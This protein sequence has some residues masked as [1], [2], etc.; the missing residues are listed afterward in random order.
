MTR[1]HERDIGILLSMIQTRIVLFQ[2]LLYNTIVRLMHLL[3]R[4]MNQFSLL[5]SDIRASNQFDPHN[6]ALHL[7]DSQIL[8]DILWGNFKIRLEGVI[9]ESLSIAVEFSHEKERPVVNSGLQ[10][11]LFGVNPY[12]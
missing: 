11:L 8:E 9:H 12:T 4:I 7:R 5:G 2:Q 1:K 3:N 6:A 10:V